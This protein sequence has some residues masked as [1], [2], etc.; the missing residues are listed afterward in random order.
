MNGRDMHT[1]EVKQSKMQAIQNF[2][3]EAE[4]WVNKQ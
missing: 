1:K 3:Y 2:S 4:P